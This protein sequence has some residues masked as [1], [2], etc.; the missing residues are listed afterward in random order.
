M[1]EK[2]NKPQSAAKTADILL[3]ENLEGNTMQNEKV[4]NLPLNKLAAFENHPFQ[5]KQDE[6]FQKL[7][8]SIKENGILIPAVARPK[9]DGYE[10]IAG[11]RRK[12]AC[13]IIGIDTM[14]VIVR[15][16]GW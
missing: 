13:Q 6:D 9:G 1:T 8:E 10:L 16:E 7:V 11:H 12:F 5:V 2:T 15:E 3:S 4:M 14:P